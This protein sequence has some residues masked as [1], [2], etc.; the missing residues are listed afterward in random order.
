MINKYSLWQRHTYS[1][2]Q[3]KIFQQN[4]EPLNANAIEV[5]AMNK[6]ILNVSNEN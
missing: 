4:K 6:E 1:Q 3:G 5:E 2:D